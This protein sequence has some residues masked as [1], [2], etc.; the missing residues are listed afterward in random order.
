MLTLPAPSESVS[1]VSVP[2]LLTMLLTESDAETVQSDDVSG[3]N[4]YVSIPK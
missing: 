2:S 1:V 4:W 3:S